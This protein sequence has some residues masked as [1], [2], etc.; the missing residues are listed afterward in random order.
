MKKNWV[1]GAFQKGNMSELLDYSQSDD[2]R[3]L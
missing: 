2:D 1:Y 3:K